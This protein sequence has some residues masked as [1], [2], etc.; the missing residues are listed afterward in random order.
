MCNEDIHNDDFIESDHEFICISCDDDSGHCKR[1]SD[2]VYTEDLLSY[3]SE[4]YCEECLP[5]EKKDRLSIK[6]FGHT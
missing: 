3:H 4:S 1:C 5:D 6:L 2:R